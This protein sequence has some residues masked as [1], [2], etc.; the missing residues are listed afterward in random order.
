LTEKYPARAPTLMKGVGGGL[1]ELLRSTEDMTLVAAE[2]TVLLPTERLPLRL[3]K[4]QL[5]F[6]AGNYVEALVVLCDE[7]TAYST[8]LGHEFARAH[9]QPAQAALAD[10]DLLISTNWP[11]PSLTQYAFGVAYFYWQIAGV[12][13]GGWVSGQFGVARNPHLLGAQHFAT[14]PFSC[15]NKSV[16]YNKITVSR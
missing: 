2:K 10:A 12:W 7:Y 6:N 16:F 8:A 11:D 3:S 5:L 9:L 15:I 13:P 1:R 4:A 14:E